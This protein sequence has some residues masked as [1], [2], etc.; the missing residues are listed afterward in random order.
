ML[1]F[2][3]RATCLTIDTCFPVSMP[4]RCDVFVSFLHS[5]SSTSKGT[6]TMGKQLLPC[7]RLNSTF[8]S[9]SCGHKTMKKKCGF[10]PKIPS[11][12]I[13]LLCIKNI[14]SE[15]NVWIFWRYLPAWCSYSLTGHTHILLNHRQCLLFWCLVGLGVV[16]VPS[17]LLGFSSTSCCPTQSSA[18]ADWLPI[19]ICSDAPSNNKK[20]KRNDMKTP[21]CMYVCR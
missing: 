1:R 10:C 16:L 21:F 17:T 6:S 15:T 7:D 19:V 4:C 12:L 18:L 2:Q 8:F 11:H 5:S 3:P 9:H 14:Q 13:C 20:M